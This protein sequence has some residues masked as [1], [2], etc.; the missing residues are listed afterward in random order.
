MDANGIPTEGFKAEHY[1]R[2]AD[3]AGLTLGEYLKQ[4]Y[5]ASI[6]AWEQTPGY[7]I[8]MR[9]QKVNEAGA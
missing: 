8:W 6:A 7:Q 2:L 9:G 1:A 3:E 4:R 5:E